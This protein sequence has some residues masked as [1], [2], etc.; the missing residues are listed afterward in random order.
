MIQTGKKTIKED[1]ISEE[2]ETRKHLV[3]TVGERKNICPE[4]IAQHGK[5]DVESVERRTTL[6]K[7]AHQLNCTNWSIQKSH[8][9]MGQ[10]ALSKRNLRTLKH[11]RSD[12]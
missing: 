4:K 1:K 6:Q 12:E 5:K 8:P 10:H 3:D 2:V 7:F 11:E 9:A